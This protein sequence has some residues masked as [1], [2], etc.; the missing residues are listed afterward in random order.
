MAVTVIEATILLVYF[1]LC[2][3]NYKWW[4][5]ALITS[6]GSAIYF[7]AYSILFYF[8][9]VH[10]LYAITWCCAVGLMLA[11]TGAWRSRGLRISSSTPATPS[12]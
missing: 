6:G 2:N 12:S 9:S 11:C 7:F 10:C 5:R 3:E 1:Q 8:K 4:W